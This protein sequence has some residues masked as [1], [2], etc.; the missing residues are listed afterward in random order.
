M[1]LVRMPRRAYRMLA[2]ALHDAEAIGPGGAGAPDPVEAL[3]RVPE[4]GRRAQAS[5][6]LP[7]SHQVAVEKIRT[8]L[9]YSRGLAASWVSRWRVV[10]A[11]IALYH[12]DVFGR[13]IGEPEGREDPPR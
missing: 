12:V 7:V 1:V 2:E 11:A 6:V 10:A 3:G 5:Y 8:E 13:E 4:G 9:M